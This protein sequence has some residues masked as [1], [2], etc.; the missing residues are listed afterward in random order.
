M[1]SGQPGYCLP[2][3][4]QADVWEPEEEIDGV[5]RVS[6]LTTHHGSSSLGPVH[7]T[8]MAMAP[9]VSTTRRK[10]QPSYVCQVAW[11]MLAALEDLPLV[12]G[13]SAEMGES[14]QL[15]PGHMHAATGT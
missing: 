9:L 13:T 2:L 5:Y 11:V 14:K 6:L 15:L 10:K 3:L 1:V 4:L 8:I 12:P 7:T